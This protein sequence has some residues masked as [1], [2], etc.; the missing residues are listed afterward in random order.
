M[1]Q[2]DAQ[3]RQQFAGAERL[4]HVVVGAGIERRDLVFLA[5]AHAQDDDRERGSIREAA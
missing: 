5:V 3:A 1:T 4:R 2:H